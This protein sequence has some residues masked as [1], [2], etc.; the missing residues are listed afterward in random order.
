MTFKAEFEP[1]TWGDIRK[2]IQTE[3]VHR[4]CMWYGAQGQRKSDILAP[5]GFGKTLMRKFDDETRP[6]PK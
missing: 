6:T 4:S 5:T 2:G 3:K 1:C